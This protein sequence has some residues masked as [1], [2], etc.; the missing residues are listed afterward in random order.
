MNSEERKAQEVETALKDL[1]AR[2]GHPY[3]SHIK[4]L[5]YGTNRCQCPGFV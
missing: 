1:C 4:K 3:L 2:C 5:C